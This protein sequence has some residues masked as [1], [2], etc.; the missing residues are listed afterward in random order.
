MVFHSHLR[1]VEAQCLEL[2]W[3]LQTCNLVIS[4]FGDNL[5]LNAHILA[6][7]L[8]KLRPQSNVYASQNHRGS[9]NST[10]RTLHVSSPTFWKH[11]FFLE[12]ICRF[13]WKH[14]TK[15][16]KHTAHREVHFDKENHKF[17]WPP[18]VKRASSRDCKMC[19]LALFSSIRVLGSC[20]PVNPGGPGPP[21]FFKI[22]QFFRQFKGV[23]SAPGSRGGDHTYTLEAAVLVT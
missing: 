21:D 10:Y 17:T 9:T 8:T 12:R 15:L 18:W 13:A 6:V 20:P 7:N 16:R 19:F 22:M 5:I 14:K 11:Q 4:T 2:I 3:T 23:D 1:R